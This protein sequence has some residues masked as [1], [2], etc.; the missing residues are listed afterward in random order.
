MRRRWSGSRPPRP[1]WAR[2]S[3]CWPAALALH[4]ELEVVE[5][6]RFARRTP[7]CRSPATGATSPCAAFARCTRPTRSSSGSARTSRSPAGWARAPRRSWPACVGRR[8]D[9][10]ARRRPCSPHATRSR[11]IPTTSP[12]RCSAASCS[13][14][15][16]APSGWTPPAGSRRCSSCRAAPVRTAAARAA[17]PAGG[18]DGRRGVQRRPR[19]AAA[20]RARS[21]ATGTSSPRGLADRLHQPRRAPP[22]SA[23][24]G[25]GRARARSSARS[26][27]RSPAPGRPCWS[28]APTTRPARCCSGWT[29]EVGA[30]WARVLRVRV[31]AA[32]RGRVGSLCRRR[33][34]V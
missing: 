10:R 12:R 33:A 11:A 1:T 3:T 4:V 31:R 9:V 34:T 14:P 29:R 7:T 6:G 18:A 23:L 8:L 25:A 15:T 21:A 17:L 13:A 20:A 27:P 32:G 24:A 19:R 2:A 28:G 5:T 16:A 26:A 22:L 30:G